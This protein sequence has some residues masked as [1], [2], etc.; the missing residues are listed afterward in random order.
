MEKIILVRYGEV[1]LKGKNKKYFID[2]LV[3]NIKIKLNN[4]EV[5]NYK[6]LRSHS[7]LYIKCLDSDLNTVIEHVKKVFGI[8]SLSIADVI[9]KDYELIKENALRILKYQIDKNNIK[10]FK[11]QTK[12]GDKEY[13]KNSMEINKDVGAYLLKNLDDIV[14]VKVTNPELTINIEIRDKAYLFYDTIKSYGGLPLG[15]TG[16]G[17]LLLSGGIDSPVAAWMMGKRG[18]KVTCVHFHSYPFTSNR[19]QEKII[20]L[21]KKLN[22]YFPEIKLYNINLLE[23]QEEINEKCN[24]NE[25]TILSRRFMTKI[26][27]KIAD[28][29]NINSLITGDNI[30]QVASQTMESLQVVNQATDKLILR[31]LL[32]MDKVDIIKIAEEIDTFNTSIQPFEDCCTVFLPKKPIIRPNIDDILKSEENLDIDTLINKAIE[33]KEI[34]YLKEKE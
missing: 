29:N 25:M 20:D 21:L 22:Q 7:R 19:A 2:A 3:K 31:P 10:T 30:G 24:P 1:N 5:Q 34:I 27:S 14:K 23:I 13:F 15:T 18:V 32:A 6:I 8:V 33:N 12:R 4:N 17:V 26:A 9:E 28:E 16:E 11:V